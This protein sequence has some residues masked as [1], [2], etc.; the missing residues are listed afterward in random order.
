MYWRL[1]FSFSVFG[2]ELSICYAWFLWTIFV[3]TDFDDDEL[4]DVVAN[5]GLA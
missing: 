5:G 3:A 4:V 2:L 1:F